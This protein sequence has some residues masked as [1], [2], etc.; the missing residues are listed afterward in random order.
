MF[1]WSFD[2]LAA[3]PEDAPAPDAPELEPCS[4]AEIDDCFARLEV[5]NDNDEGDQDNAA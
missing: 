2:F 3:Q 5:G 1:S 4:G